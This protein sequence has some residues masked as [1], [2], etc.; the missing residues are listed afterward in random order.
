MGLGQAK[1][2]YGELRQ[3]LLAQCDCPRGTVCRVEH[4]VRRCVVLDG[5]FLDGSLVGNDVGLGKSSEFGAARSRHMTSHVT[6]HSEDNRGIVMET[7]PV[8]VVGK[9]LHSLPHHSI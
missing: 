8:R 2:V 4:G 9:Y 7:Q 6:S 5:S 1:S 3:K